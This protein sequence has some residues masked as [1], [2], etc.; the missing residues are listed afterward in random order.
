MAAT[1]IARMGTFTADKINN[2][3]A[4]YLS[5]SKFNFRN[6]LYSDV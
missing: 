2:L 3:N 6:L 1:H 5:V 4:I